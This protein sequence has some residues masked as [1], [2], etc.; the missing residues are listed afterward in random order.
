MTDKEVIERLTEIMKEVNEISDEIGKSIS[1]ESLANREKAWVHVGDYRI[2]KH[3]ALIEF[4]YSPFDGQTDWENI[5][6]DQINFN[7]EP[8]KDSAPGGNQNAQI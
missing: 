7:G 8:H 3:G 2:V 4:L 6:P 5:K 1:V